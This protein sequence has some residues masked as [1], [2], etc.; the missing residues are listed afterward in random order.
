M[1]E[2]NRLEARFDFGDVPSIE[3]I[4][5]ERGPLVERLRRLE[6]PPVD[7]A[8]R[9]RCWESFQERIAENGS[10]DGDGAEPDRR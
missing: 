4:E 6:W 8:Y 2:R 10:A 9:Q 3:P 7:P 5:E 1:G